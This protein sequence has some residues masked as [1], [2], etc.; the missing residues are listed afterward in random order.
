MNLFQ[1]DELTRTEKAS[2]SRSSSL[3]NAQTLKQMQHQQMK[4]AI[5]K[6]KMFESRI[7]ANIQWKDLESFMINWNIDKNSVRNIAR[8]VVHKIP[9]NPSRVSNAIN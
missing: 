3:E 9:G 2:L 7:I 1:F 4:D 8:F 6:A 5:A